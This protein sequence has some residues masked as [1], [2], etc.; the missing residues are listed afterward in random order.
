MQEL[1]SLHT[2]GE[3]TDRYQEAQKILKF[4]THYIIFDTV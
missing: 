2:K 3:G 4:I 1:G